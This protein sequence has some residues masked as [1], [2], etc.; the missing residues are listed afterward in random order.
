MKNTGRRYE[1]LAQAI[2]VSINGRRGVTT[3]NPPDSRV[4]KSAATD[5]QIDIHWTFESDEGTHTVLIQCK[6]WENPVP[7]V[8]M[9]AFAKIVDLIGPRTHGIFIGT[10]SISWGQAAAVSMADWSTR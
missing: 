8:E 3:L 7:K 10:C 4:I 9:L 1:L 6:D 2:C 5:H